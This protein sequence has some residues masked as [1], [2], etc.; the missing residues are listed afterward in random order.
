[1]APLKTE[2]RN[3][4]GVA[5]LLVNGEPFAPF[6]FSHGA[7]S[8]TVPAGSEENLYEGFEKYARAGCPVIRTLAPT[9]IRPDGSLDAARIDEHFG[10]L[11]QIEPDFLAIVRPMRRPPQWWLD[12]HPEHLMVHQD[13][14]THS[15]D[16]PKQG[17]HVSFSS[18]LYRKDRSE[19]FARIVTHLEENF[20][21]HIL[22]YFPDS[23]AC[24]EW[25]Y[26]W[27]EV[28]SDFSPVQRQGFQDWLG[29]KYGDVG[30]L[31]AAWGVELSGFEQVEIPADRAMPGVH[32]PVVHD[33]ARDQRLIDYVE[34]HHAVV[35]DA[36]IDDLAGIKE[37]LASLG[38]QKVCGTWFGYHFWPGG[39]G[40][41]FHNSGHHAVGRVFESGLLD[42]V[43]IVHSHQERH[44]GGFYLQHLPAGSL[45]LHGILALEEDD[46]GTHCLEDPLP[47]QQA[48]K[49]FRETEGVLRRN[50]VATLSY[51]G[52]TYWH[53][54]S[55]ER[56]FFEDP[57]LVD[58]IMD[59]RRLG[60]KELARPFEPRSQ[61]AVFASHASVKYMRYGTALTDALITRQISEWMHVG[62][63]VDIYFVEDL[64]RLIEQGLLDRY[65]VCFFLDCL[66]IDPEIVSAIGQ[67]L[68]GD[69]RTLIWQYAAGLAGPQGLDERA[70]S[71]L[72]GIAV[73]LRSEPMPMRVASTYTGTVLQYG[74]EETF[75]P[76]LVGVGEKLE[77]GEVVGGYLK[78]D[79]PGLVVRQHD[80]WRSVWSGAPAMPAL[81]LRKLCAEAGVHIYTDTG[82]Q[83]LAVNDLLAIHAA[84][85]GTRSIRLPGAAR[86]A[87]AMTGESLASE[88]VEA[89][90]LTLERGDTALWRLGG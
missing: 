35:G 70:M 21:D 16:V 32:G 10:R 29:S 80:R 14:W 52:V 20:G 50:M 49:D 22:G 71:E 89:L 84:L 27:D 78:P 59:L 69:G 83:V 85:G 90:D 72:M 46:T 41:F 63:P 73:K 4:N 39:H 76:L 18:K 36:L 34:Y 55:A 60:Q 6:A 57:K 38:R 44:P 62:A 51:G 28:I 24:A 33:P 48:C 67:S 43:S 82:D 61:V 30:A 37:T 19:W 58:L 26:S 23:G 64:D 87:D 40:G 1:M 3:H 25:A 45:N 11:K 15:L 42:F 13:P 75:G 66:A 8:P 9:V 65:R 54:F 77:A 2:V 88:P 17:T 79:L 68:C 81:L 7:L 53:D 12:C 5:Q 74:T 47:W 31:N 56:W 86:V